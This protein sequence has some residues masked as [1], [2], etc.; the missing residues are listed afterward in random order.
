ME[1]VPKWR[2]GRLDLLAYMGLW[3][4]YEVCF[5]LPSRPLSK[6]ISIR[7][8]PVLKRVHTH[9]HT[10]WWRK[11]SYDDV[12]AFTTLPCRSRV[13]S[14][15]GNMRR[16]CDVISRDFPSK[17]IVRAARRRGK[18]EGRACVSVL[19]RYGK[20]LPLQNARAARR[21]RVPSSPIPSDQ[22]CNPLCA[23]WSSNETIAY[24]QWPLSE[25]HITTLTTAN[26]ITAV[27]RTKNSYYCYY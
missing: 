9:T 27:T 21:E 19:R 10:H 15:V 14:T 25:V 11:A 13:E 24:E 5:L 18:D 4:P 8:S 22:F 12:G 7:G 26:I 17:K 1:V 2:C 20:T 3:T 23:P 6:I 16:L